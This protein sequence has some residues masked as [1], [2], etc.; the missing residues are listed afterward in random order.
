MRT[1]CR[2][3]P[4]SGKCVSFR[5]FQCYKPVTYRLKDPTYLE[6]K[7][8]VDGGGLF[9]VAFDTSARPFPFFEG[10]ILLLAGFSTGEF[11][12]P[13]STMSWRLRRM[14]ASR[15][16]SRLRWASWVSISWMCGISGGWSSS[17]DG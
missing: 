14:F 11:P 6:R 7:V 9:A 8:R 2:V 15:S 12:I 17:G 1:A 4:P 5:L 10:G 13:N 3:S 16:S